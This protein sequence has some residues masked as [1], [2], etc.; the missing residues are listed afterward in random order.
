MNKLN[1]SD[2]GFCGRLT[3]ALALGLA[4]SVG[5]CL[6]A[7]GAVAMTLDEAIKVAVDS[8]PAV[9]VQKSGKAQDEQEI[10]E[11]RARYRPS[12]DTTVTTGFGAFNN[13]TTRFRRTRGAGGA[14]GL[15]AWHN[16][17]RI[18]LEQM[19]FDGFE[20][21]NL[22]AAARWRTEVRK[23]Q[24]RGAEEGIAVRVTEAYL[25]V[26]RAREIVD[27]AM[28]NVQAHIETLGAVQ[29]LFD[30]G[31]GNQADVLQATSRLANATDRLLEQ[32]GELRDAEADFIEAVGVMPDELELPNAP[33][34]AIPVS[35]DEAITRALA[36]NP[37]AR[38][39]ELRIDARR[40]DAEAAEAPFLPRV[41]LEL[42]VAQS[43]NTA[44]VRS[45]GNSL[46]AL[47]VMRY[48]LYRG[49]TDTARLRRAR[50]FTSQTILESRQTARLIEE[51]IRLDWNELKTAE[52]RLP[53][54][55]LRMLASTQVV[56]AYRQQF[57]ETG[58]RTL[59]DLLDV[60]NEL[61]QSRVRLVE[62]EYEILFAHYLIL[63][64]IGGLLDAHGISSQSYA[65]AVM[66]QEDPDLLL[67]G[68]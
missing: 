34:G 20:T 36:G 13:N 15:R 12:I 4:A 56:E 16:E 37:A 30:S 68:D 66:P 67:L 32:K 49:G 10:N 17:A 18:E 45:S 33:A 26:L 3:G 64:T 2:I 62:G 59:L 38:A 5:L 47:V 21:E 54:L 52:S 61:F 8:H 35:L 63:D 40:A 6:A 41:D 50:E 28:E 22:V 44:G 7:S 1:D 11:A 46:Q 51:Q 19:L 27:L 42:S 14:G 29:S 65:E 55:E 23:Q 31:A 39:A 58:Q 48:N 25:E 24:I 60:E 9:L 57:T 43:T 53:Q